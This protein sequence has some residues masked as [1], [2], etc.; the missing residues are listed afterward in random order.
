MCMRA[1]TEM[2][3]S[4]PRGA[5]SGPL[6]YETDVLTR[7][8]RGDGAFSTIWIKDHQWPASEPSS[9]PDCVALPRAHEEACDRG[10]TGTNE[11]WG[12]QAGTKKQAGGYRRDGLLYAV[13]LSREGI[14]YGVEPKASMAADLDTPFDVLGDVEYVVQHSTHVR[15]RQDRAADAAR[16]VR[17]VRTVVAWQ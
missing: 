4:R 15:V 3:S 8:V 17:L 9:T 12:P 13:K 14:V 2:W 7:R 6:H 11:A 5:T 1:L 16:K 10:R